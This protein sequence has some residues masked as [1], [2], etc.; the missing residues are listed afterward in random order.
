MERLRPRLSTSS[1]SQGRGLLISSLYLLLHGPNYSY[2]DFLGK[3]RGF[4]WGRGQFSIIHN[5][6]TQLLPTIGPS[7][8]PYLSSFDTHTT[9]YPGCHSLGISHTN[10]G[11][12]TWL[13]I[14][15]RTKIVWDLDWH[16]SSSVAGGWHAGHFRKEMFI[17]QAG[18]N[19]RRS[20]PQST[21]FCS[22]IGDV[23]A[24]FKCEVGRGTAG[25]WKS[26]E[27]RTPTPLVL[28]CVS[29]SFV[30]LV[31]IWKSLWNKNKIQPGWFTSSL[32]Q[33]TGAWRLG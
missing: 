20:Q 5:C 19:T 23:G 26:G 9:G 16:H 2:Y 14:K 3:R 17:G 21:I 4:C 13:L 24:G 11:Q 12:S 30:C 7:I 1:S 32:D 31:P 15:T 18:S 33:W 25:L 10:E 22:F 6:S 8:S 27:R 28:S 29:V